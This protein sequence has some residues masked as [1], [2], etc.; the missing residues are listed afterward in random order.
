MSKLTLLIIFAALLFVPG[1]AASAIQADE[2][3]VVRS[4]MFWM[5]TCGHC[6]YV[7]E[8]VLP[9]LQEQYGSQ[10][11]ITLIE[12]VSSEDADRMLAVAA[13]MGLPPG[14][15]GVPF[16]SSVIAT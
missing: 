5:D 11:V 4:V 16:M 14:G 6:H 8:S 13:E 3:P 15:V 2:E 10:L 1:G 9:P 12:I 7:L